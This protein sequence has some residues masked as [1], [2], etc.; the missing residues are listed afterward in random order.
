MSVSLSFLYLGKICITH[1]KDVTEPASHFSGAWSPN[2]WSD[3]VEMGAEKL[4]NSKEYLNLWK[5]L[6]FSPKA[7]LNLGEGEDL[8]FKG[9]AGSPKD[10]MD[11]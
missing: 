11:N 6:D 7:D 9:G 8:K 2:R 3:L 1:H 4:Y 10:T 5:N